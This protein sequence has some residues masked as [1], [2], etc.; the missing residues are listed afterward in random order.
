MNQQLFIW[1]SEWTLL[2][3][4]FIGLIIIFGASMYDIRA[5]SRRRYLHQVAIKL[6][7]PRQPHITVLIHT[8]NNEATI[9]AC[10]A[11]VW[12]SKYRNYDIVV[13]DNISSDA[14]K[15]I[16]HDYWQKHSKVPLYF[17][18]KRKSSD[19]LPALRQGYAKSQKGD[20]VFILDA[21]ATISPTLLR[22]AAARFVTDDKLRA[23]RLNEYS[24][25]LYSVAFLFTRM[26][27]LSYNLY[28]KLLSLLP[29]GTVNNGQANTLYKKSSFVRN[30]T[31]AKPSFGYGGALAVSS[32]P[33]AE[34]V[35]LLLLVAGLLFMTYFMYT[36]ATL[37][38]SSLLVLSWIVL[39]VWL[40]VVVWSDEVSNLGEKLFL[41]ICIPVFYFMSYAQMVV[42]VLIKMKQ[43]VVTKTSQCI[44]FNH[45]LD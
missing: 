13:V 26:L 33:R 14:T 37:Q 42:D 9:D 17:Y 16:I 32:P 28:I 40:L 18:G 25:D 24:R 15:R 35:P 27:R 6:R 11:S 36:A 10:L 2:L 38:T 8:K 21:T 23:L 3:V 39:S 41:T 1:I 43:F 34:R 19:R 12:R 22:E 29:L 5:I 31:T 44:L 30:N 20:I 7:K 4:T 45:K